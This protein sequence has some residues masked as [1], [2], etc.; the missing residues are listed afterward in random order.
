[1]HHSEAKKSKNFLGGGTAHSPD[2]SP[3]A[4]GHPL[5]KPHPFGACDASILAPLALDLA[6]QTKVLDPPVLESENIV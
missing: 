1:M 3:L 5:P 4:G 2:S 6:P